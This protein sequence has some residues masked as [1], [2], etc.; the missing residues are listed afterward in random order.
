[1]IESTLLRWHSLNRCWRREFA[2]FC[3]AGDENR[4]DPSPAYH[5][6]IG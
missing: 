6:S 5:S 4:E 1:M 3:P 2:G